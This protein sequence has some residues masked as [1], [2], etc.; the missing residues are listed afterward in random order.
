V[1][2]RKFSPFSLCLTLSIAILIQGKFLKKLKVA[3]TLKIKIVSIWLFMTSF[4]LVFPYNL[5]FYAI[6]SLSISR[7]LLVIRL[8]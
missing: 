2:H 3:P 1:V 6:L 7:M 8:I 4:L 5:I